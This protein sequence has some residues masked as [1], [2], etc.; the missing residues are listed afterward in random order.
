MLALLSKWI[1][2]TYQHSTITTLFQDIIIHPRD[3]SYCLL[4]A[5]PIY[6]Q[7]YPIATTLRN[8]SSGKTQMIPHFMNALQS[9]TKPASP[10][11]S[12]AILSYFFSLSLTPG[13]LT[14]LLFLQP[15]TLLPQKMPLDFCTCSSLSL[16]L[17]PNTDG[18]SLAPST[19]FTLLFRYHLIIQ[20]FRDVEIYIFSN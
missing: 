18:N 4:A 9:P 8:H 3:Y 20:T 6:C 1:H 11:S 14:F 10:S 7:K 15:D 17:L 19:F 16:M 13:I 5:L 12:S 2:T